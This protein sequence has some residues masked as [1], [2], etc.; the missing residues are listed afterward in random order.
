MIPSVFRKL[1]I[2]LE[3]RGDDIYIPTHENYEVKTDIDGSISVSYTHLDV[4][5]RQIQNNCELRVASCEFF[6]TRN[7]KLFNP[8][9]INYGNFSN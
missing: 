8:K 5:K 2:T 3:R 9:L 7:P 4:Y 6:E 1:G